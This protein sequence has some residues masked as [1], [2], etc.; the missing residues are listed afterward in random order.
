MKE[1]NIL[2]Y[3]DLGVTEWN[4]IKYHRMVCHESRLYNEIR[5]YEIIRVTEIAQC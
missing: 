1:I 4:D 3:F 2:F 5:S